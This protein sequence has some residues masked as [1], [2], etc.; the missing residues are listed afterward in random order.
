MVN[1][2]VFNR[3]RPPRVISVCGQKVKVRIVA[4]LEDS[5]Q[6]LLGAFNAETKTIYLLR[7]AN[8]RQ[9]LLHEI[10]H[11][12]LYFSGASEGLTET[13][14]ESI[15]LALEHGLAPIVIGA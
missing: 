11:A 12:V 2:L 1:P 15:V 8:W 9:T 4:Y 6:E 7:G 5:N 10:C 3:P 13:K 14:E